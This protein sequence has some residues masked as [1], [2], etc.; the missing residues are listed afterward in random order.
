[1]RA[2]ETEEEGRSEPT[3]RVS[4][5]LD[6]NAKESVMQKQCRVFQLLRGKK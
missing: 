3:A 4:G 2:V 6:L 5:V 1:M